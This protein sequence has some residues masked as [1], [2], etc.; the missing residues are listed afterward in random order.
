M[1]ENQY[2]KIYIHEKYLERVYI[3]IKSILKNII[4]I[5]HV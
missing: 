2:L 3:R 1:K 5:K 4:Y